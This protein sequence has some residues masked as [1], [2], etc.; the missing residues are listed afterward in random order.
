MFGIDDQPVTNKKSSRYLKNKASGDVEYLDKASGD[1]EDLDI[2]GKPIDMVEMIDVN[3]MRDR[4]L[5][6]AAKF[7]W[8]NDHKMPCVLF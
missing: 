6:I 3:L 5:D 7:E 4:H 1:A 2:D 8:N